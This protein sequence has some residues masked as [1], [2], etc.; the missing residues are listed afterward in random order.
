MRSLNLPFT[1]S[2][3]LQVTYN[4]DVILLPNG[5]YMNLLYKWENLDY[6]ELVYEE[7]ENITWSF[8]KKREYYTMIDSWDYRYLIFRDKD[9]F[10]KWE[11]IDLEI[12]PCRD[13]YY[14]IDITWV[15]KLKPHEVTEWIPF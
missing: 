6:C 5:E 15:Y 9:F 10:M 7:L 13:Y 11:Y 1:Y 8:S 14:V 3:S 12:E 2:L 4:E